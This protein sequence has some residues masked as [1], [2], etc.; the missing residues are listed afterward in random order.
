[1]RRWRHGG[2]RAHRLRRRA[3]AGAL[4][5]GDRGPAGA[6]RAT[7]Y[8]GSTRGLGEADP[9]LGEERVGP[10]RGPRSVDGPRGGLT[11]ECRPAAGG[12]VGVFPEHAATWD[13]ARHVPSPGRRS[14]S[15]DRPRSC[16]CSAT[17]AA[18]RSPAR[19]RAPNVVHVDSSK[20]AVGL[21][22]A[23]RGALG[24]GRAP[25]P[26]DRGGRPRVRPARATPRPP[27]RRASCSTR[28]ATATG[29][30]PGTSRATSPPLLDDLAAISGPKPSFV[31]LS[32]HTPGFDGECLGAL[33]REHFAIAATA[34]TLSLR[35]RA[36]V[37]LAARRLGPRPVPLSRGRCGESPA[38]SPGRSRARRTRA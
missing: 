16:R 25:D 31:L 37:K 23:Q 12:Q 34:R 29:R 3:P 35:A 28:R 21:G 4:R 33:V 2:P 6:C 36:G 18:R 8:P 13:V 19:R 1:M 10:R 15:V 22:A 27:L 26:V 7:G 5:R 30:A 17:P 9:P 11:L 38:P 24:P 32:A 14:A 20:P